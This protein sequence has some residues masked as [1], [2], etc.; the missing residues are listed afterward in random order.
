MDLEKL[1]HQKPTQT[2]SSLGISPETT[3][4]TNPNNDTNVKQPLTNG[5]GGYQGQ[6]CS[7]LGWLLDQTGAKRLWST[8][9]RTP[10]MMKLSPAYLTGYL[11]FKSRVNL[12]SDGFR[13]IDVFTPNKQNCLEMFESSSYADYLLCPE[14]FTISSRYTSYIATWNLGQKFAIN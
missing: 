13:V 9:L 11:V 5:P 1:S 10:Y 8:S 12:E 14:N 3:K 7:N 4:I 2:S 6:Y